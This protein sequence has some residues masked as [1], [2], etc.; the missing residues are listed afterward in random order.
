MSFEAEFGTKSEADEIREEFGEHLCSDDDRRMKVVTFASDTPADL[1]QEIRTDAAASRSERQG[2]GGQVSLT[3][4]EKERIDFSKGRS[5]VPHAR[6][7]KGIARNAGVDDWTSYY[8]PELTVDEHR[9][10]M[11]RASRDE[12]GARMDAERT[13]EQRAADL[14]AQAG[15]GDCE[16]ARGHCEHGDPDACEFLADHCGFSEDQVATILDE[17]DGDGDL[18]GPV[19]GAIGKQWTRYK[20]GI[21]NAKEAAAAINEIH[22]HHDRGLVKFEQ[23]GGRTITKEDITW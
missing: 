12:Q 1:Q 20:T 5:N 13:D 21:A 3:E 7:V 16:H 18:P 6:S 8:D 22:R 10:V 23:L 15:G 11:D 14:A 2:S 9:E 4:G 17:H 19:Y